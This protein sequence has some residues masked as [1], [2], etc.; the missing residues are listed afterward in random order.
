MGTDYGSSTS[1]RLNTASV[2]LRFNGIWAAAECRSQLSQFIA[3]CELQCRADSNCLRGAGG[4]RSHRE[5]CFEP[6]RPRVHGGP[7]IR[8]STHG[9]RSGGCKSHCHAL[10]RRRN[11]SGRPPAWFAADLR[12]PGSPI[13]PWN[14]HELVSETGVTRVGSQVWRTNF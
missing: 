9:M 5:N 14:Y 13:S 10:G 3:R 12:H 8:R 7:R 2:G 4:A 6:R 11:E 1:P